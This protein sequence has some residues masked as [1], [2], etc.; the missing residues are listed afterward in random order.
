MATKDPTRSERVTIIEPLMRRFPLGYSFSR[1]AAV[2]QV[3]LCEGAGKMDL[4]VV[5]DEP[6][7]LLIE[8]KHRDCRE[9]KDK[10]LGQVILYYAHL[11]RSSGDEIAAA[12][13]RS[14]SYKPNQRHGFWFGAPR[15]SSEPTLTELEEW[16]DSA[17]STQLRSDRLR[18]LIALDTWDAK[19]DDQR[20]LMAAQFLSERGVPV[21]IVLANGRSS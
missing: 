2:R 17:T 6:S 20:L 19:S 13:V 8:A 21:S 18:P 10:V 16:I 9:A 11:V 1:Y 12:V 7:I 4:V 5:T 14:A 15:Q 3:R